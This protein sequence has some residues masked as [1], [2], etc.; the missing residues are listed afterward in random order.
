MTIRKGSKYRF[1]PVLIDRCFGDVSIPVGEHVTAGPVPGMHHAA[2][3][4]C[5]HVHV[6]FADGSHA[7]F[8]HVNSLEKI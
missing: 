8:V 7:G 5:K 2:T 4:N 3:V 1:V 6:Y